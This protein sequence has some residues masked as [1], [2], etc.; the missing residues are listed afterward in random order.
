MSDV[1]SSVN[2][3]ALHEARELA[4][5]NMW[6]QTQGI[7][8]PAPYFIGAPGAGKTELIH[9]MAKTY[10]FSVVSTHFALKAFEETGGVPQIQ[11]IVVNGQPVPG[12]IWTFP[13]IMKPLYEESEKVRMASEADGRP[14]MVVWM[15]DDSHLL[16]P[17]HM[18]Q[19]Y[20]TLTERTLRGYPIPQNCGI[21]LAG[22]DGSSM[23]GSK[24]KF[25]AIV[26][27]C[28]LMPIYADYDYWKQNFALKN[29]IH[30]AIIS[31]L[32]QDHYRS[33]FHQ[34]EQVDVAWAS[35]RSWTG[36]SNL[37]M[38]R[39]AKTK[40]VIP[41]HILL[42][43]GTGIV[44][45]DAASQFVSYYKIYV[46]F[47]IEEVLASYQN[48]QVPTEAMDQYALSYALITFYMGNKE[49]SKYVTQVSHIIKVYMDNIPDIAIVMCKELIAIEKAMGK[50]G[51]ADPVLKNLQN[52]HP[53]LL[54]N[55]LQ[56]TI[57][58]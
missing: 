10:G 44:G 14:R 42:Y 18:T 11:E 27:R 17:V 29:H 19:L 4:I 20:E 58:L 35:P 13:D 43:I 49:R 51:I 24:T 37:L 56:E 41:E 6:L 32:S 26:N 31:F 30:P 54:R 52:T 46:K 23:A 50:K 9:D 47:K 22:N 12:T 1:G 38:A 40:Q 39:E 8:V 55:V 45:A 33:Y 7:K 25:S 36:F 34:E 16:G 57:N 2:E 48:F 15:L 28:Q 5:D 21:M 3:L 53:E